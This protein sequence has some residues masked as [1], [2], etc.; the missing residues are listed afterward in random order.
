MPGQTMHQVNWEATSVRQEERGY[1]RRRV[2]EAQHIQQQLWTPNLD[3]ALYINIS[4]LPLLLKLFPPAP[5]D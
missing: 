4:W 5:L 3:Y 1:W 2:L